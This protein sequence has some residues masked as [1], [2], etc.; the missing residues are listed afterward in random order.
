MDVNIIEKGI[1]WIDKVLALMDKY[2]VRT[3]L[4]AI[5]VIVIFGLSI[6]SY[7]AVALAKGNP[8]SPVLP[9]CISNISTL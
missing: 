4:K 8:P 9:L 6:A 5:V 2:R 7:V 3:I 1:E